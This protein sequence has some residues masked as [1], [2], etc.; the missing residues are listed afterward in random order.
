MQQVRGALRRTY[1]EHR[2]GLETLSYSL[3]VAPAIEAVFR[4]RE[5]EIE[6]RRLAAAAARQVRMRG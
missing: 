3:C 5:K 1:R 6:D 4:E 2:G